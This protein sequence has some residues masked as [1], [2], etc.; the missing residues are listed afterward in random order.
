MIRILLVDDHALVRTG[1]RLILAGEPDMQVI[2][3]SETGEDAV[4]LARELMPHV[5]VMDM[6][7]PGI[8]GL[9]STTRILRALP[10]VRILAVTAQDAMPTPRKF[11]EVGA[12]GFLSKACPADELV[13]AIRKVAAGGRYITPAA[14]QSIALDAVH[15]SSL[16]GGLVNLTPRETEVLLSVAKGEAMGLIAARLH[17]SI[18]TIATH[19]YNAFQK[20]GITNDVELAHFAIRHGL[21][22]SQHSGH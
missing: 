20:I 13:R 3:E 4:R 12:S 5:I 14:A 7:L 8:S 17:L 9:E 6:H 16:P 15:G 19:K 21:I 11:L 18:K 22:P 10:D 2:G 1:F